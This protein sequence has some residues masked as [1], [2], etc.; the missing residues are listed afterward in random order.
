MQWRIQGGSSEPP[1]GAN[2][3]LTRLA[4]TWRLHSKLKSHFTPCWLAVTAD[5]TPT[6]IEMQPRLQ[7]SGEVGVV[8]TILAKNP[9]HWNPGSAPV[10]GCGGTYSKLPLVRAWLHSS[11][12]SE[13]DN[14][15]HALETTQRS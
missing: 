11:T 3:T 1:F 15:G 12:V 14:I 8:T 7:M 4:G 13:N 2:Q 9:L 6:P 10:M 5:P